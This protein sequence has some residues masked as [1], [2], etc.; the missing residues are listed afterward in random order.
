MTSYESLRALLVKLPSLW[1]LEPWSPLRGASSLFTVKLSA[2]P[3]PGTWAKRSST[4]SRTQVSVRTTSSSAP[5]TST[6]APTVEARAESLSLSTARSM[7]DLHRLG[8]EEAARH[9][10]PLP[11]APDQWYKPQTVEEGW[12]DFR[13]SL[14]GA[15]APRRRS[16]RISFGGYVRAWKAVYAYH[17]GRARERF[18]V[19]MLTR[20]EECHQPLLPAWRM[21]YGE[22]GRI[23]KSQHRWY[24]T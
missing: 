21:P 5:S 15:A 1:D 11:N 7:D 16:S 24:R 8:S 20:C 12:T 23:C 6:F 14:T 22:P 10:S 13:T 18:W 2:I 9:A 19:K 3:M 17:A 4:A